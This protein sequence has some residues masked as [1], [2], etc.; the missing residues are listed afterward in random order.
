MLLKLG[1]CGLGIKK[2]K[3]KR[4]NFFKKRKNDKYSSTGFCELCAMTHVLLYSQTGFF[5]FFFVWFGWLVLFSLN[6][7][8]K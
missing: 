3:K 8:R 7:W 2:K 5:S 1:N 4:N 6:Y